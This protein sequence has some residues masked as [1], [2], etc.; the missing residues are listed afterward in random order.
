M[1]I[2][3]AIAAALEPVTDLVVSLERKVDTIQ[4]TP[5]PQ[6]ERGQDGVAAAAPS[7]EE[8]A[9][10]LVEEHAEVLRGLP[11]VAPPA[12]EIARQ[13]AADSA[14]VDRV[15]GRQGPEGVAGRDGAD[16][17]P[18]KDGRDGLDGA[19]VEAK[20]Y[21]PGSVYR[22]GTLVTAHLGQY[23][24]AKQDTAAAPGSDDWERV[25]TAG[26]RYCGA[27]NKDAHYADGDIY[28]K[29]YGA[30]LVVNGEAAMLCG[31]GAKGERGAVGPDGAP[32]RDGRDGSRIIAAEVR[33]FAA[34]LVFDN[35][36]GELESIELDFA[37]AFKSHVAEALASL[38]ERIA[39]LEE[40]AL[41]N[42]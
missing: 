1:N 23:Y 14:F 19:G 26:F 33:G 12:E 4:L 7:A 16:G 2:E 30:F 8:I 3:K 39:A 10:V 29:D 37:E 27:Y 24:R 22:E 38:T 25:G 15:Q 28:L 13:L 9:V 41:E 35:G 11:G 6:G 36:A 31:R 21:A 40:L 20:Q 18:G 5:G 42:A 32:G 34:T 17:S